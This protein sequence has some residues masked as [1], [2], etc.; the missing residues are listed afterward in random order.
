MA[1][2]GVTL[3]AG[4]TPA[5]ALRAACA[6]GATATTRRG[7]QV[8]L[9][10]PAEIRAATGAEW[11]AACDAATVVYANGH[12]LQD[13]LISP[14]YGDMH[15]FP[16]AI[17]TTGT[18]DLLLSNTVRVHRALRAAGVEA[19]LEVYEGQSHAQYLFDDRL[20]ETVVAFGEIAEFFDKHLGK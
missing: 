18:R 7:T 2:L 17:L 20:P 12:D 5:E 13:P 15:G 9:P 8:A 19:Q 3:A 4:V 16:P 10:R 6:A 14:V 1:A 11:P